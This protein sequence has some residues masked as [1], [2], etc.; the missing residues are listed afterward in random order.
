MI[1]KSISILFYHLPVILV[2]SLVQSIFSCLEFLCE[3][4]IYEGCS[5]PFTELSISVL[6]LSFGF[7]QELCLQSR[8]TSLHTLKN[9]YHSDS[10]QSDIG[11]MYFTLSLQVSYEIEKILHTHIHTHTHSSFFSNH[12]ASFV[13]PINLCKLSLIH[14]K[15]SNVIHQSFSLP[16]F[17]HCDLAWQSISLSPSL[18]FPPDVLFSPSHTYRLCSPPFFLTKSLSS[19]HFL[20]SI[21]YSCIP[22]F[23]LLFIIPNPSLV[24]PSFLY[25]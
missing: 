7:D 3:D 9:S 1:Y 8:G 12:T 5:D 20:Y 22:F 19:L 21:L 11:S 25:L 16:F 10:H 23:I 2:S 18:I 17:P 4:K 6:Y 24:F 15:V 14:H 13:L